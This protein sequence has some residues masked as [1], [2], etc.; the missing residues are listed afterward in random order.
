VSFLAFETVAESQRYDLVTCT[1]VIEELAA[2]MESKFRITATDPLL[3]D[4]LDELDEHEIIQTPQNPMP[5]DLI[6]FSN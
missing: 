2:K 1:L 5:I 4:F 3:V 6:S